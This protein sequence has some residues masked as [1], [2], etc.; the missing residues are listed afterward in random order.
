VRLQVSAK[1]DYALRALLVL[2][3]QSTSRPVKAEV[4]ARTQDIPVNYLWTILMQLRAAGIV[5]S[6]RGN[7]GGYW[8]AKPADDVTVAD[9]VEA[10][11]MPLVIRES[12]SGR[13]PYV[14]DARHLG[15]VWRA[16]QSAL[17]DLLTSVTLADIRNG[18]VDDGALDETPLTDTERW[19]ALL[20][21]NDTFEAWV[22]GWPVGGAIELHDHGGS[23]G[24]VHVVR[25]ALEEASTNRVSRTALARARVGEDESITFGADH[26]H[27]VVNLGDEPALSIHVYAPRLVS[28]TFYDH[29]PA[30]FLDVVRHETLDGTASGA[31]P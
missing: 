17:S 22:I 2:S 11:E 5:S 21:A 30:C 18:K 15:D 26:V 10:V 29:R 23:S 7:D 24:A 1:A 12:T 8:L 14:G 19:Y 9:V 25:G 16:A 20:A 3:A 6:L 28:M 4:L 31:H 13:K 27:D